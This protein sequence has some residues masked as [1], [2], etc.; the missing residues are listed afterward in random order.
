MSKYTTEVRFICETING[1]DNSE[2]YASINKIIDNSLSSIFD[3]DFPIFDEN[4]RKVL[5]T[6]I[7]RHYYT[8]EI[9][10]ETVGLWKMRLETKLN[11]I[12]PYYNK[13]YNSEL[14][15]YNPLYTHNLTRT[16]KKDG[17]SHSNVEGSKSERE[18]GTTVG[19]ENATNR[20]LYSDTPQGSVVNLENE[21]YL[22]NA[23]KDINRNDSNIAQD[24][25]LT[26]TDNTISNGNTTDNYLETV[27]G[28][29]GKDASE[30]LLKYRKTFLNIDMDI[31]R[32][33][34]P[35]FMQ[36]W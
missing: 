4:Y 28:Y 35:L 23:S 13:L 1:L 15:E 27:V 30:M 34:E 25:T 16:I 29:D 2:G 8:R 14:L 7:I 24:K 6:K 32:E 20:H 9:G 21:T 17:T 5:E 18:N 31:I 36:L 3:F 19:T 33:L 26:G 12:M 22:T 11:E 10:S